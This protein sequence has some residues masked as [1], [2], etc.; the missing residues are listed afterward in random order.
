MG[1]HEDLIAHHEKQ[2][3]TFKQ[4]IA[5]MEDGTLGTG[6]IENGRRNDTTAASIAWYRRIVADLETLVAKIKDGTL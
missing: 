4:A 2:I 1:W 5:W 6:D 3:A